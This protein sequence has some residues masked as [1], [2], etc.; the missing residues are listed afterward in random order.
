MFLERSDAIFLHIIWLSVTSWAKVSC[1]SN[2][3]NFVVALSFKE[4]S[5][6]QN[7]DSI[8]VFYEHKN[9]STQ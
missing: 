5:M 1:Q 6:Y 2:L 9:A 8:S 7:M 4:G 3:T